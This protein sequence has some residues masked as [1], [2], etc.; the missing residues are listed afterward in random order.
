MSEIMSQV[1]EKFTVVMS[2]ETIKKIFEYQQKLATKSLELGA[3]VKV[4]I[5]RRKINENMP[6]I[7]AE[8][9]LKCLLASKKPQIFAESAI[10]G[11]GV[12]W[13]DLELSI[14]GDINIAVPVKVFDNMARG[15]IKVHAIPFDAELLYTP[16]CLLR[17]DR[18][19]GG[20]KALPDYREVVSNGI[21]NQAAYNELVARRLFPILKYASEKSSS[22]QKA[23]INI[24]GIGCGQ[25]AGNFIGLVGNHLDVAIRSL[26]QTH[27]QDL[28]NIA[29]IRFDPYNECRRC[30]VEEDH[31][32]SILYRVRPLLDNPGKTQLCLPIDYQENDDDFSH[33]KLFKVVAWDQVSLP[34]NDFWAGSRQTD[35]GIAAAATDSMNA[36]ATVEGFY[37]KRFNK[38]VMPNGNYNWQDKAQPIII[39]ENLM[40]VYPDGNFVRGKFSEMNFSA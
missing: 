25:F 28:P 14:L 26:L 9:L 6:D 32:G 21:I 19:V 23:L 34:G 18:F 35:D 16:G 5:E 27:N 15:G 4:I 39:T 22:Q 12:D 38:F 36:F 29:L 33:C 30:Q 31:F 7:T 17:G 24:P 1:Q 13:N 20:D 3:Y 40:V 8:S 2:S 37:D 11:A 10:R